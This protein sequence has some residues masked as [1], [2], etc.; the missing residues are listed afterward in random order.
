MGLK[1]SVHVPGTEVIMRWSEQIAHECW[2]LQSQSAVDGKSFLEIKQVVISLHVC[3]VRQVMFQ[4]MGIKSEISPHIGIFS[5]WICAANFSR[6]PDI[7]LFKHSPWCLCFPVLDYLERRLFFNRRN[8]KGRWDWRGAMHCSLKTDLNSEL[9]A[10]GQ[11]QPETQFKA[12]RQ[13]DLHL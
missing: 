12:C 2:H 13:K 7:V 10:Q 6:G 8:T 4:E 11:F 3:F 5:S 9:A 1:V